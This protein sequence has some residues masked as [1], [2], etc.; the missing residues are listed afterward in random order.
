MMSCAGECPPP[1]RARLSTQPTTG[2]PASHCRGGRC[3]ATSGSAASTAATSL[4]AARG[5]LESFRALASALHGPWRRGR[6]NLVALCYALVG[7]LDARESGAER[8]HAE[9]LAHDF[10]L[11]VVDCIGLRWHLHGECAAR[12]KRHCRNLFSDHDCRLRKWYGT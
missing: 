5:P 10:A 12:E 6:V 11:V 1:W 8:L 3:Q 9:A 2:G 7:M 4:R